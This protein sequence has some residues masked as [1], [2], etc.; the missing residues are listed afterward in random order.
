[1]SAARQRIFWVDHD[2]FDIKPDKSTWLEMAA[3]LTDRGYDVSILTHGNASSLPAGAVAKVIFF[4]AL[5]FGGLFRMSLL[6]NILLWLLRTTTKD[7]IIMVNP[8]GLLIAPILKLAGRKN[9]HLDIRTV[10]VEINSIKKR[11][12]RLL[13]WR[14][15]MRFFRRS[16]AGYSFITERLRRSVEQEFHVIFPDNVIWQSGVNT[17]RFRPSETENPS[18]HGDEFILFYHGSLTPKRGIDSVIEAV[19]QLDREYRDKIRFVIV[20]GGTGLSRL[21]EVASMKGVS[22]RVVF[23]GSIVYD[24]VAEEIAKADCCI[25]PLPDRPEWSVSSPLK[26]FEYMACGK[27]IIVTQ[28][29]AHKDVLDGQDFAVW[30]ADAN[31]SDFR[32]A[33]EYAYSNREKLCRDAQ[34]GPDLVKAKYDWK[35]HA[36][37][38]ADYFEKQFGM[39]AGA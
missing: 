22:D 6:L 33:I 7:D 20:G 28:M 32:G 35:V 38:L 17:D 29:P 2:R 10:P 36:G 18:P 5:D 39:T 1:M 8:D 14:L 4:R 11:V 24:R 13:Y 34:Q 27:P 9:I 37:K 23:K 31:A 3:A 15:P 16:A 12:D 26:V 19:A 30:A 21:Q 25:C